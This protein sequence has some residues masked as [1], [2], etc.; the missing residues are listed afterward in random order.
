MVK[1]YFHPFV[2]NIEAGSLLENLLV[3]AISSLL[4]IRAFLT[5]T[6]YP[7]LGGKGFHIAHMLWGGLFM[8][9]ALVIVLTFLNREALNWASVVG[10]IGF[11]MFI[12]ELGKFVTSDNNYFYRPTVALIYATFVLL[13]LAFRAIER[14]VTVSERV[15]A[16]NA[17]EIVKDAISGDLDAE[18]KAEALLYL[19]QSNGSD[20]IVIA[21]RDLLG[22][23]E[24]IDPPRPNPV[25]RM[26]AALRAYYGRVVRLR[27]FNSGV[28]VFFVAM[29]LVSLAISM[30][31]IS[32]RVSFVDRMELASA[33]V[34]GLFVLMG[35]YQMLRH[36][37]LNAYRMFHR[38]VLLNIFFTQMFAFYKQQFVAIIGLLVYLLILLSLRYVLRQETEHPP[39]LEDE[40]Q[41]LAPELSYGSS[42]RLS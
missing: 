40:S 26:K 13:F 17:L 11:G 38:S 12:D 35:I 23:I 39:E 22:G 16:L 41:E 5:L 32:R 8:L 34:A 19:A 28:I 4:V 18:E 15:Y 36:H 10:G 9:A 21:L 14:F 24:T 33:L 37:R 30:F 27:L 7:Q 42:S 6:G 1:R 20:P 2:R 31:S 25:S 29:S 3:S